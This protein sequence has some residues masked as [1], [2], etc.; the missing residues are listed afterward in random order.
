MLGLKMGGS[1]WIRLI[2]LGKGTWLWK[3]SGLV[4]TF[5]F[6]GEAPILLSMGSYIS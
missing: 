3:G 6:E 1:V 4:V 5:G 2:F